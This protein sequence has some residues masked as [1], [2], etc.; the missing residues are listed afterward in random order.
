PGGQIPQ[1]AFDPVAVNE[2]K[3][4]PEPN[5]NAAAGLF[6]NAST[7]NTV[8]DHNMGQRIDFDNHLTGD[9]SFYYH[10][11]DSTAFNAL[12]GQSGA[13]GPPVP[14]FPGLQPSR[15]PLFVMSN[16]KTM[17]ATAV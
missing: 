17:G 13:G 16:T 15:N 3:Y 2:L 5:I 11:D 7:A 1:S 9:W 12:A 10:L 6:E 4:I 8:T 14:G